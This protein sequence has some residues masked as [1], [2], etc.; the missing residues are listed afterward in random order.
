MLAREL[1]QELADFRV[2]FEGLDQRRQA[3]LK[4]LRGLMP[5]PSRRDPEKPRSLPS[6][7]PPDPPEPR[8]LVPDRSRPDRKKPRGEMPDPHR[9]EQIIAFV[10]IP[11][12]AGATVTSMLA[13]AYSRRAMHKAGNY[14]RD[15]DHSEQK[16]SKRAGSWQSWNRRGGRVSVGHVPYGLFRKHMPEDTRYMTFLREP[17]DRVLSH[18]YRHIHTEDQ[19]RASWV[20]TRPGA[21]VKAGSIE[22]AMIEMRLPQLN[23]LSTR[24]LSGHDPMAELPD[25]ALDDAKEHL[26]GFAFVGIQERFEESVVL[27]QRLLGLGTV[28]PYIDRHVSDPGGRPSV[29]EVPAEQRAVIADCNRLDADLYAF[30]LGLFEK[31]VAAA[32]DGLADEVE[33]LRARDTAAREE[34]WRQ[35][36]EA[37]AARSQ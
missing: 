30:G 5:A 14:I 1:E 34:E 13:A 24:F 33:D 12:T 16:L 19:F 15:Q 18:Y 3:Q 28:P 10:H 37:P 26:S 23:N 36:V 4:E 25:S 29:N 11:K 9:P 6:S 35:V 32:G 8:G 17:V 31:A 2:R 21:R 20:K 7:T 27:L 22:Q